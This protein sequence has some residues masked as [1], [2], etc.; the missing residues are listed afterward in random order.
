MGIFVKGVNTYYLS[1]NGYFKILYSLKLYVR[2]LKRSF[3]SGGGG[4]ELEVLI[5]YLDN[6]KHVTM[7]VTVY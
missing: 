2:F 7:N 3:F 6:V 4:G 5:V 1:Y